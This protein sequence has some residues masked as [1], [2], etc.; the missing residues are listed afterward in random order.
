MEKYSPSRLS[1]LALM[2]SAKLIELPNAAR[3]HRAGSISGRSIVLGARRRLFER[4]KIKSRTRRSRRKD[5]RMTRALPVPTPE[6][7][8]GLPVA[9]T[10][11]QFFPI[12]VVG[13]QKLAHPL[14]RHIERSA[15]APT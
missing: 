6:A 1:R 15:R 2:M 3:Y 14:W 11:P 12:L 5:Q 4:S 7:R 10:G 13:Y 9:G 8:M